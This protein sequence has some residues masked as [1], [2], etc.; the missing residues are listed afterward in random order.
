MAKTKNV[1]P[2]RQHLIGSHWSA[3]APMDRDKHFRVVNI[4]RAR[5]SDE[6]VDFIELEAV[7][8]GRR[9]QVPKEE[10]MD[11]SL[12]RSDWK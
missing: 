9:R 4:G 10:L 1:L 5:G 8:S 7:L 12:W 2:P 3:T 11:P 6:G